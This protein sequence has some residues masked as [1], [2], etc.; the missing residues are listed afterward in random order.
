MIQIKGLHSL[1]SYKSSSLPPF[2]PLSPLSFFYSL[3]MCGVCMS[4]SMCTCRCTLMCEHVWAPE[5]FVSYLPLLPF[6]LP[7]ETGSLLESGWPHSHW[8]SHVSTPATFCFCRFSCLCT[9]F[10]PTKPF[11]HPQFHVLKAGITVV[12]TAE[13]I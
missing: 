13:E 2:P 10:L 7:F 8:D 11:P 12:F 5:V 3:F 6:T 9:R 1:F 4:V